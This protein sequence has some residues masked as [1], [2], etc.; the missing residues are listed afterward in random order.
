MKLAQFLPQMPV[1]TE[2]VQCWCGLS[3]IDDVTSITKLTQDVVLHVQWEVD[4]CHAIWNVLQQDIF[5]I[6]YYI[7]PLIIIFL[8][9]L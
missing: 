9:F 6:I 7:L 2:H 3:Q 8:I 4:Q 1:L 5:S